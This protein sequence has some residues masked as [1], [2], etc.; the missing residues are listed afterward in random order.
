MPAATDGI[1]NTFSAWSLPL[2]FA[3]RAVIVKRF[4][5]DSMMP[6]CRRSVWILPRSIEC[7]CVVINPPRERKVWP[8]IHS[9][10]L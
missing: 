2:A 5:Q 4:C 9:V 10:N 6:C 3:W 1:L 7:S 8:S